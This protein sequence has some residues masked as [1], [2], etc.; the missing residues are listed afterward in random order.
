MEKY[1]TLFIEESKENLQKLNDEILKVE[2]DPEDIDTMNEIFRVAHTL[3][4]MSGTMGFPN[5]EELTHRMENILE[6]F[7]SEQLKVN[8]DTVDMLFECLDTLSDMVDNII[9]GE[10]DFRN[11]SLMDKLDKI[12]EGN[13]EKKE[14]VSKKVEDEVAATEVLD[15][16]ELSVAQRAKGMDYNTYKIDITIASS[17]LIKSARAYMIIKRLEENGEIIKSIPSIEEIEDEEFDYDIE[18]FYVSK[19]DTEE[20]ESL[21]DKIS[22]IEKVSVEQIKVKDKPKNVK[23]DNKKKN[24]G[25]K[26]PKKKNEKQVS[27]KVKIN[28]SIRV[29]LDK[30]DNFMN[31]VSELVIHRTRIE[32]IS[33]AYKIN[34]LNETLEQ[35][36]RITTNL[37]DLV[38]QM[39]M[40]PIDTVFNRF[41]RMVRDVSNQL[42][43][44][45]ELVIKGQET[46]LDRTVITEL[47]D[48]MV[49]LI[50]NAIDH[51]I[52]TEEER[53]AD[54]KD[55]AGTVKMIAYQEGNKGII[56]IEDDGKG[57]DPDK[58]KEKCIEKNI[59]VEGL[60]DD[61]IVRMIF[62][63]G[64]STNEEVTNLSGRGVGMDVVKRKISNLGGNIDVKSEVGK[65]ST[66][67]IELPLTLSIIKSILVCV[68]NEN[69]AIPLEFIE[70][71]IDV[72]E[73][74]IKM[75]YNDEV[76]MYNNEAVPVIR[77]NEKLDIKEDDTKEKVMVILKVGQGIFALMVDKIEGEK[78]IVIKDLGASLKGAGYY[79]GATILGDGNVTLILDVPKLTT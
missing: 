65:G 7:R 36:N 2:Q 40:V 39:R 72:K 47:G 37:Q 63:Q 19:L 27:D 4:G 30:L 35:V 11:D 6:L 41:P 62:N 54:G 1:L 3:K 60:D 38:L 57:I 23:T 12:A 55:P 58:I 70:K 66:F 22:E 73:E 32:D 52:E 20:V 26:K 18:L 34:D 42:G 61:Q 31:L 43:K 33:S 53:I 46:E 71:I 64:F 25:K 48:P 15:Q 56:K 67:T 79:I 77:L 21:I 69:F 44:K 13:V 29:S 8:S 50:R 51:G 24:K 59:D 17:C 76:Y 5:M 49:H 10:G 14:D 16:Y 28:Q 45:V 75:S 78:E 74:D 68:D 9:E